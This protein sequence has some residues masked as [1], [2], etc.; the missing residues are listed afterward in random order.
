[1]QE[2]FKR[3]KDRNKNAAYG[4]Y[5]TKTEEPNAQKNDKVES[6]KEYEKLHQKLDN[7]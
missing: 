3:N 5:Q 4:K 1:M 7:I 6:S 2:F